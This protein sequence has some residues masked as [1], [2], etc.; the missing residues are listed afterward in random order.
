MS[1]GEPGGKVKRRAGRLAAIAAGV[2][3]LVGETASTGDAIRP[4]IP[5]PK[6][7]TTKET[8]SHEGKLFA[9]RLFAILSVLSGGGLFVTLFKLRHHHPWDVLLPHAFCDILRG[10]SDTVRTLYSGAA[11][12]GMQS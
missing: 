12:D 3:C 4:I 11:F 1:Q 9:A 6:T 7:T 10:E 8:K 5:R 2:L